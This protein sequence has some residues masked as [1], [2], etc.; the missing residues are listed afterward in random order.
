MEIV[1]GMRVSDVF[2]KNVTF[3]LCAE[4]KVGVHKES[5]LEKGISCREKHGRAQ[6]KSRSCTRR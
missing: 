5:K 6:V 3:E 4:G 1:L 2:T